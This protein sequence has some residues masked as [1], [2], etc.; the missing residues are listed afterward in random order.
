MEFQLHAV[1]AGLIGLVD[2]EDVGDLHDAGLDRL[3]V[4]THAGDQHDDG[5]L[6][7]AGDLDFVLARRRR[8]R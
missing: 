4:V 2:H 7:D 5:H 6:R 3:H 8:S 1:G